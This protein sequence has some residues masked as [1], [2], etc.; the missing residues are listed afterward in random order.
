MYILPTLQTGLLIIP[1]C[2]HSTYSTDW[3][4]YCLPILPRGLPISH[5]IN[6]SACYTRGLS[7]ARSIN[8]STHFLPIIPMGIPIIYYSTNCLAMNY[9]DNLTK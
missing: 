5:R 9:N 4:T 2:L 1:R 7:I 6:W 3:S 8:W